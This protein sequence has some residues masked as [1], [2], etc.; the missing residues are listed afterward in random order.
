[1]PEG[2][3]R[4]TAGNKGGKDMK[5]PSPPTFLSNDREVDNAAVKAELNNY[6][7]DITRGNIS[8]DMSFAAYALQYLGWKLA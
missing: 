1:M 6:A 8:P 3:Q 4:E 2:D 7:D 5:E